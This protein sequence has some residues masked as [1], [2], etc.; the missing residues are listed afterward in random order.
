MGRPAIEITPELCKK[1]ESLA[2]QGGT[3]A[4]IADSLGMGEST[5]YEKIVGYP[6]FLEALTVGKS[7]GVMVLKNKLFEK[8]KDGDVACLKMHLSNNSNYSD[9]QELFG[10]L[11]ITKIERVI[12][13]GNSADRDSSDLGADAGTEPI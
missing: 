12:K 3:R 11:K 8:A 10:E 13:N 5:L 7:K 9:K 1:A 2:A 6:E 4:E